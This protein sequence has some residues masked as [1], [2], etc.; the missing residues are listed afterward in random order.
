L[1]G[2][3][4]RVAREDEVNAGDFVELLDARDRELCDRLIFLPLALS[5][6][7]NSP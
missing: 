5:R 7:R 6:V 2:S 3:R 1:S 4:E